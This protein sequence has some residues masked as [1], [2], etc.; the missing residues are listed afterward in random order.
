MGLGL[1]LGQTLGGAHPQQEILPL[2]VGQG[3]T[4]EA[5]KCRAKRA[6]SVFPNNFVRLSKEE[7]T[8]LRDLIVLGYDE[9][10]ARTLFQKYK[11]GD[12]ICLRRSS[13]EATT[14]GRASFWA[15][16]R[17]EAE[18]DSKVR[19]RL[20]LWHS[21][22]ECLP[23]RPRTCDELF[24][25]RSSHQAPTDDRACGLLDGA[26]RWRTLKGVLVSASGTRMETACRPDHAPP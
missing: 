23:P 21:D 1:T 10:G 25:R 13:H 26:R 6:G 16:R 2:Q 12:V 9:T 18:A 4:L 3:E 11:D 8:A 22:G 20:C 17:C 15:A 14:D 24:L 19:A 7:A 5:P